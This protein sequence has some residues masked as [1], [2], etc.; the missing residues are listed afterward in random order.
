MEAPASNQLMKFV[1]PWMLSDSDRECFE[2]KRTCQSATKVRLAKKPAKPSS[3]RNLK[4]PPP[5]PALADF[6]PHVHE[7]YEES[8][9]GAF[10]PH[11]TNREHPDLRGDG[12]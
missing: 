6:D 1:V 10:D 9:R 5:R 4:K 7:E 11:A 8:D 12:G 3:E 2:E